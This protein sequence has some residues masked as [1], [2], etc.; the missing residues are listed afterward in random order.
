[1]ILRDA[2]TGSNL[3]IQD[4]E[5]GFKE[6]AVAKSYTP[7]GRYVMSEHEKYEQV[8]R[9]AEE[10]GH[11]KGKLNEINEK[12]MRAFD[13]YS[14]MAQSQ[15]PQNWSVQQ[16]ALSVVAVSPSYGAQPADLSALMNQREL[17]A[18]LQERQTLTLEL[19]KATD[20]LKGLAPNLL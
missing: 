19:Q 12:L 8:G 2:V 5:Q 14:R 10:V 7:P 15:T 9:L 1:M 3:Q 6:S 18:I 11:L 4:R 16:D 17:V 20:R 13:A